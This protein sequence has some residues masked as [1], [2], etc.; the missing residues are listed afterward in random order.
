MKFS[1]EKEE[2]KI[3]GCQMNYKWLVV[4]EQVEE[5]TYQGHKLKE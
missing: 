1:L 4:P 5:L 2:I 3:E